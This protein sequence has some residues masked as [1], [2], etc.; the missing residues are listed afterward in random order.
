MQAV[1]V[2][3]KIFTGTC[4]VRTLSPGTR[5]SLLGQA[6]HDLVGG[7]DESNFVLLRVVHQAHNNLSADLHAQLAQALGQ[8]DVSKFLGG[9][10]ALGKPIKELLAELDP[11]HFWQIHR[12]TIVNA[13][14]VLGV[15][16]GERDQADLLLKGRSE[17]LTV[18]RNYIHLFR[19]M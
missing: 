1:E 4:T 8:V 9:L 13:R 10:G 14:A 7:A 15:V 11:V 19:Q 12:S 16:R 17:T 3:N 5:F 6:G 2:Q 18:S